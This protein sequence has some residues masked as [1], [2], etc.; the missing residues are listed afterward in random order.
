MAKRVRP[1]SAQPDGQPRRPVA[2]GTQRDSPRAPGPRPES[3]QTLAPPSAEAVSAFEKA[4]QAL[5]RHAYAEAA[6]RFRA[7]IAGFP[8]EG[9]LRERSHVYLALCER[10]LRRRPAAPKTIEE[11]LTAATAALNDDDDV[12]AEKLARS[13]LND[14]PQQELALYLLAAVEARR[15]DSD[16]ALELLARALTVSPEIRAQARHDADFEDL[17]ELEAF[18][19][20]IDA[21]TGPGALGQRRSRRFR[22]DR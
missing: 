3:P 17:R 13:V 2:P 19:Q 11:R 18:R 21:P 8:A 20:L 7:L 15:G 4:M 9:A 5:Q 14:A 1:R 16:E 22:G 12:G 6:E 10:E